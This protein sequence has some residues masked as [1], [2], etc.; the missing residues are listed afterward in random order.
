M[1][2]APTPH[3]GQ[4]RHAQAL[5]REYLAQPGMPQF[6]RWLRARLARN[7]QF[8]KRDRLIYADILFAAV[9]FGCFAAF[10]MTQKDADAAALQQFA[11]ATGNSDAVRRIFSELTSDDNPEFLTLCYW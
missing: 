5:W 4:W 8:G 11:A 6:D 1:K 7:K 2:P 3:P 10:V 9:R